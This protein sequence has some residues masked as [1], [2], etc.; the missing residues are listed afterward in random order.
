MW[1][2]FSYIP[3][4]AVFPAGPSLAAVPLLP[5]QSGQRITVP[6]ASSRTDSRHPKNGKR[7]H[8]WRPASTRKHNSRTLEAQGTCKS[9]K[10][11]SDL[12]GWYAKTL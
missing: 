5:S 9:H 11:L 2:D 1:L 6:S 12:G 3:Q 8:C 7:I 4:D 10:G